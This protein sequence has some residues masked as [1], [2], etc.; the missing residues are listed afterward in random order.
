MKARGTDFVCYPVT[1][2]EKS[3]AF[4]RDTLG[5]ELVE[6]YEGFWAEFSAPPT[7]LALYRPDDAE[8]GARREQGGA[9]IA[10]ATES[11]ERSVADLMGQ[12]VPVVKDT[13][14]TPVCWFAIIADPDGNQVALHQR[15]DGTFG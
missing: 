7:T 15:K 8:A 11:V 2:M 10:L 14:D 3:I 9:F 12:G 1:D 13:F 4:Y 5:L 6:R